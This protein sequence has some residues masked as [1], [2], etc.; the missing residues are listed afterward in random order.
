MKFVQTVEFKTGQFD[1]ILELDR[2]WREATQGKRTASASTIARDRDQPDT[3]ILII[4]FPSFEAAMKN[5]D[6]PETQ[7]ISQGMM[8][9]TEGQPVFRNFDVV[10]QREL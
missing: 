10:E 2:R 8:K 9:L 5:N 3:Y 7:E 6:L 4:E 1:A